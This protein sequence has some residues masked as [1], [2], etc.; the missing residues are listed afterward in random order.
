MWEKREPNLVKLAEKEKDKG[1]AEGLVE[2][3][4]LAFQVNSITLDNES[5]QALL[6]CQDVALLRRLLAESAFDIVAELEEMS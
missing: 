5:R 4:L 6:D 2:G 1:R 3:I